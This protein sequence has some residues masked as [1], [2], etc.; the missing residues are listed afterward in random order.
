MA[1]LLR[2]LADLPEDPGSIPKTYMVVHE[3]V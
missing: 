1:Q 3:H 2:A